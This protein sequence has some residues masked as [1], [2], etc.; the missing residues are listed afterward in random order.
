MHRILLALVL[1]G[2]ALAAAPPD[3][4]ARTGSCLVPG[5]DAVCSVWTGKV[6]FVGDG[7]TIY[8]NVKGEG[9]RHV[10]ITGINAMEQSVYS[11][12]AAR[13]RGDCHALEATAR[14]EE[15][16]ERG[17]GR[18]RL[19]AQDPA[20]RSGRR[21][22]RS[23]G[24]RIKGRWRD[25]GRRLLAEGHALWLPNNVEHVWNHDY[26]VLAQRAARLGRGMWSPEACGAG[27]G[28]A[29]QVRV[30]ANWDAD[31]ADKDNLNGEWIRVQNLDPAAELPL[32]GWWVRDSDLRRYTFPSWVTLPP[33][34]TVT[35]YVGDGPDTWT[36]LFWGLRRP[37]F[38]NA[39]DGVR[40]K[41]DGAY[42]FDPEGD[43][44]AHMMYPCRYECS[45]PNMGAIQIG[46]KWKGRE[47]IT[48]R[49]VAGHAID[50]GAYRLSSPPYSYAFTRDAVLL[51]GEE[52][53]VEIEGDPARD[54]R[55]EKHWGETG[56]ILNNTGDRVRLS[57]YT[58]I[59]IGCFS[60]GDGVC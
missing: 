26:S 55:L 13:R 11:R 42:L 38:D 19:A 57:S 52:M 21:V 28:A 12:F 5:V 51:P 58:D 50:L 20:S 16:I 56:P 7:D 27:P 37:V 41:G 18:V 49:N 44:R 36:E 22:R 10:R 30:W 43:L 14:L 23:V 2:A 29:G 8:V 48:L 39:S 40:A 1:T 9:R 25:V 53:R 45:D 3:A 35:V 6:T 15:L 59:R 46:A 34:E 47:H 32:G 60:Y 31:G 54:T 4:L 17:K 33:G 24:V